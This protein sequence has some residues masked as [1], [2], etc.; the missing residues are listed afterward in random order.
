LA[1]LY[2]IDKSKELTM[3]KKTAEAINRQMTPQNVAKMMKEGKSTL[4]DEITRDIDLLKK[5]PK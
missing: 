2:S 3:D 4:T 5:P 1:L